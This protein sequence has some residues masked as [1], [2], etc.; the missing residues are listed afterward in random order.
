MTETI[1][2]T[3]QLVERFVEIAN[4]WPG[5]AVTDHRDPFE[6]YVF[7]LE[8]FGC[9]SLTPDHPLAN[10]GETESE[11]IEAARALVDLPPE[12]FDLEFLRNEAGESECDRIVR[13]ETH[14]KLEQHP[15]TSLYRFV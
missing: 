8:S 5:G 9:D 4:V 7:V 13:G 6:I 3:Q 12:W 10:D 15:E 14:W 1:P 2:T 11:V